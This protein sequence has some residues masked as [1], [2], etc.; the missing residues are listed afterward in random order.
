VVIIQPFWHCC[1]AQDYRE[2]GFVRGTA[3]HCGIR[4]YISGILQEAPSGISCTA[5]ASD[6]AA[7]APALDSLI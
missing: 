1:A 7:A 2:L 3:G 6:Q 4:P 5:F